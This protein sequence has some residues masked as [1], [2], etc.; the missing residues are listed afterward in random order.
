MYFW[1]SL[2]VWIAFPIAGFFKATVVNGLMYFAKRSEEE[3]EGLVLLSVQWFS[4]KCSVF[5]KKY[6]VFGK[7]S[8][9]YRAFST[10]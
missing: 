1:M 5:S 2:G 3:L 7:G 8:L 9:Q 4:V 10:Q 6:S